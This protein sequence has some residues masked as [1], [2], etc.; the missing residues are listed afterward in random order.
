MEVHR[1]SAR[2]VRSVTEHR[3]SR[4]KGAK[5]AK[6]IALCTS[7][8]AAKRGE[9]GACWNPKGVTFTCSSKREASSL[10]RTMSMEVVGVSSL[11]FFSRQKVGGRATSSSGG[12]SGSIHTPVTSASGAWV[13]LEL[14]ENSAQLSLIQEARLSAET[15]LPVTSDVNGVRRVERGGLAIFAGLPCV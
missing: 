7:S 3:A 12:S 4:S 15:L 14:L 13:G 8:G 5:E 11:Q 2:V 1:V 6:A 10:T 9:I